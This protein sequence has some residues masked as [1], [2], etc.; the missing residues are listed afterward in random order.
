MSSTLMKIKFS[1]ISLSLLVT[2]FLFPIL[3]KRS[4]E[5]KLM[6][7]KS[8]AEVLTECRSSEHQCFRGGR[9]E[10]IKLGRRRVDTRL[11]SLVAIMWFNVKGMKFE[12]SF[13]CPL[14]KMSSSL[15]CATAEKREREKRR[16]WIR[17][18]SPW[19]YYISL[20]PRESFS[21]FHSL[22]TSR[23]SDFSIL[24]ESEKMEGTSRTF[25]F[26]VRKPQREND[27][28]FIYD[29]ITLFSP[30]VTFPLFSPFRRCDA[31]AHSPFESLFRNS[32]HHLILFILLSY[33]GCICR[34]L[35]F[36]ETRKNRERDKNPISIPFLSGENKNGKGSLFSIRFPHSIF[37]FS[38]FRE[39]V[40]QSS[41]PEMWPVTL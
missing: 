2:Q 39:R 28:T 14:F 37:L 38:V 31:L 32:L 16:L 17:I 41:E 11:R 40:R 9:R 3:Q 10:K 4:R 36:S 6:C 25:F 24:M 13:L 12:S 27:L 5:N 34:C 33:S 15:K 35:H 8:W 1:A 22:L 30:S 19:K 7:T 29:H 18:G 21:P 20:P 23:L 26:F